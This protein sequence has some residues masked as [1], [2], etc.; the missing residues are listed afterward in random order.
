MAPMIML[1][2]TETNNREGG[3]APIV[4]GKCCGELKMAIPDRHSSIMG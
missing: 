1:L 3:F 4:G 2:A